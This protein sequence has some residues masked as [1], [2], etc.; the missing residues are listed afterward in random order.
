M[1]AFWRAA[2]DPTSQRRSVDVRNARHSGPAA[3]EVWVFED[4]TERIVPGERVPL[5]VSNGK[6]ASVEGFRTVDARVVVT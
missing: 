6:P 1:A 2:P 3:E 5:S 4:F